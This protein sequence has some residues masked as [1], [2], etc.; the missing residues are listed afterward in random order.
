MK[1]PIRMPQRKQSIQGVPVPLDPY[2]YEEFI[3]RMN[4]IKIESTGKTLKKS[5]DYLVTK[6]KDY[7]SAKDDI[8]R[9]KMIDSYMREVIEKTKEE[10]YETNPEIRRLVDYEHRKMAEVQ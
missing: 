2:E 9:E 10:M 4:N 7:K 8:Q 5:L 1:T 6:D 3:V